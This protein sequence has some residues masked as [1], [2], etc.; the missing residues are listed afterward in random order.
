[1]FIKKDCPCANKA[2]PNWGK[3]IP[4]RKMMAAEGEKPVCEWKD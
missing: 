3:C 1:M 4:C 2:C